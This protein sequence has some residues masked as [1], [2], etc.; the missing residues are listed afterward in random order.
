MLLGASTDAL[1][2]QLALLDTLAPQR[3]HV[4]GA[5]MG[6]RA[7]LATNL[8]LGLNRAV[9]AEGLV[10]AER[11]GIAPAAFLQLVLAT[12][13]RS[14]A[15]AVKGPLMVAGDFAPQLAHPP[16][17]EGRTQL[18]LDAAQRH[19]PGPATVG[20]AR[21]AAAGGSGRRRR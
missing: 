1:Q 12:P 17:P 5:G 8:V 13:A 19:R 11:L 6:A 18:M 10:F 21:G 16:A 20:R 7:K 9:L 2:S 14:D 3:I 15:A 4:G